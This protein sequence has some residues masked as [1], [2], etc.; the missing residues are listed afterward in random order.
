MFIYVDMCSGICADM[1]SDVCLDM[2]SDRCSEMCSDMCSDMCMARF[3][4]VDLQ[5]KGGLGFQVHNYIGHD[6]IGP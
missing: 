6:Y 4:V 2:C 5:P 3:L 1:C